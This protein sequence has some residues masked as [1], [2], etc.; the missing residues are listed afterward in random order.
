VTVRRKAREAALQ[1][2]YL[3]E[4]GRN[5]PVDAIDTFFLEHQPEAPEAL[6][7]F[8]GV[9]VRGTVT[10]LVALDRLIERHLTHWRLERVAIIDRLILRMA[11]WELSHQPDTPPAVVLNEAVELARKYSTEDSVRFVN[12]VLDGIRKGLETDRAG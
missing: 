12:G 1:I 5:E 10:D 11:A 4:V 9:L 6:R 8:A 3:W 2:L 7:T